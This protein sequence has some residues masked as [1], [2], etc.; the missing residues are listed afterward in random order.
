MNDVPFQIDSS[1]QKYVL[2]G[3]NYAKPG[4]ERSHPIYPTIHKTSASNICYRLGAA[5]AVL[6]T[7]L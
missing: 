4:F 1:H 5:G 3:R 6:S 2:N 7:A